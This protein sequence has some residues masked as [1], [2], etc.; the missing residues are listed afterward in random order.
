MTK[1]ALQR[2]SHLPAS[3]GLGHAIDAALLDA[4]VR[5]LA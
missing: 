3:A 5:R 2:P 4:A 1:A